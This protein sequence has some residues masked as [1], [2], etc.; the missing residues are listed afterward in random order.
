MLHG[1]M[2][3]SEALVTRVQR[4][5]GGQCRSWRAFCRA[6]SSPFTTDRRRVA[7]RFLL[8]SVKAH[9]KVFCPVLGRVSLSTEKSKYKKK[10]DRHLETKHESS[11]RGTVN[12]AG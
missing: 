12:T 3:V 4:E 10:A 11:H 7:M 5:S 6:A 2:V 9:A 1:T 8:Y